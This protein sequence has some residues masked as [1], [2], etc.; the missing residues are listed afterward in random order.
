V[1][2]GWSL[3]GQ[4]VWTSVAAH[5]DVGICLART[6]TGAPKHQG[7]TYFLVDMK[8]EGLDVRRCAR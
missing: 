7:I 1:E 3:T 8:S 6:N 4:K 5:A 2:G